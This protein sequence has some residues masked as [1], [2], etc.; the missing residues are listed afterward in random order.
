MIDA[1][2]ALSLKARLSFSAAA[3]SKKRTLKQ[4]DQLTEIDFSVY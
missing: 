2:A 3:D 1:K 4:K